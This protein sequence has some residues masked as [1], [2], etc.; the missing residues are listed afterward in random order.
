MRIN[1]TDV[2]KDRL[3]KL[4]EGIS[5]KL[6]DMLIDRKSIP[7][8]QIIEI[9][10]S[11]VEELARSLRIVTR[12]ERDTTYRSFLLRLILVIG[13][14]IALFGLF[15]ENIVLLL[16]DDPLRAALVF[17]GA[18]IS[19]VAAMAQL[20][21]QDLKIKQESSPNNTLD[22]DSQINDSAKKRDISSGDF[23]FC[24][25]CGTA[26]ESTFQYCMNCGNSL[27]K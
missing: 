7:G 19:F 21:V 23:V 15:Y 12:S 11:D 9:T 22:F 14:L 2:A 17:G 10:G 18:I 16:L 8:E 1:Y 3:Q 24:A 4:N 26:N 25:N 6:Q 20:F 27:L 13:I 5:E